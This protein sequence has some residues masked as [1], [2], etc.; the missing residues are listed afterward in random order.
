MIFE[1]FK[2]FLK[3]S[4][5]LFIPKEQS[6]ILRDLDTQFRE[7]R[8]SM[9]EFTLQEIT[10]FEN[11]IRRIA[12][13]NPD[14]LHLIH[15]FIMENSVDL[16]SK[17]DILNPNKNL[18]V[19]VRDSKGRQIQREYFHSL[20]PSLI[21]DEEG[22]VKEKAHVPLT[23]FSWMSQD[24]YAE[25]FEGLDKQLRMERLKSAAQSIRVQLSELGKGNFEEE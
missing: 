15:E 17:S 22:R 5:L 4:R 2:L 6:Q 1:R 12:P 16:N 18:E 19:D 3:D 11:M 13:H 23:N 9:G 25:R 10:I 14:E 7:R 8:S 20:Q 21:R 24:Y